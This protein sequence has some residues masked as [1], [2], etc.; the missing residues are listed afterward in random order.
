MSTVML[1]YSSNY[2]LYNI[3]TQQQIEQNNRVPS[4]IEMYSS[5]SILLRQGT[6]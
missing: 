5:D 4:E 1:K 3:I 2:S 6:E